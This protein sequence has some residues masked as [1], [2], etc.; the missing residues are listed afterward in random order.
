MDIEA[1]LHA[2]LQDDLAG[3]VAGGRLIVAEQSGHYVQQS[4]PDLV[5]DAIRAVVDAVR[6]PGT[7]ATPAAAG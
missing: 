1:T 5:V 4:Q 3:L 7:W 2:E 6:D